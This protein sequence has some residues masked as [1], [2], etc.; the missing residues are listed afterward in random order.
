MPF[1]RRFTTGKRLSLAFGLMLLL[2]LAVSALGIRGSSLVFA[3]LKTIYEDRTIPLKQI[4]DIDS[5][6]LRNRILVTEM[7]RDPAQLPTLDA[8][9]Q[10]NIT[11]ITALWKDYMATYLT[12]EEKQL[13]T[14]FAEVRGHYVRQGLLAARDAVKAGDSA[15]AQSI[16][17][18]R[19]VTLGAQAKVAIDALLALQVRVGAESFRTAEATA[20]SVR[21]WSLA[22]AL[23]AVLIALGAGVFT[24]RSITAPMQEAVHFAEAVAQGDL[25]NRDA[26]PGRDEAARLIAALGAMAGSLR[27]IV[28]R[29]RHSSESIA[30]G[31]SEI[32]SGSL[33]LSQRTEEQ[34]ANLQQT[35][36]S[37]EQLSSTVQNNAS[38]AGQADALATRAA[39]AA[40]QGGGVVQQ[41][42]RTMQDISTSS[43][44]IAD[45][46]GVIDSIAFQT[47][48]LALNAAVEAARAGE[49]GKGFAVV[50]SEVR[51]LAQRSAQAARE[52]KALIGRSV[53]QVQSGSGL[54]DNAGAA[55]QG[56]VDQVRQVSVLIGEIASASHEQSRGIQQ[57]GDAVTQLDQV[58]QQNAALVEESSAAADSLQQQAKELAELVRVFRLA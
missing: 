9:L 35:A 27:D 30:T 46:I 25:R 33:D 55:M 6:M 42:V 26:T 3:D 22:A 39:A 23:A 52:I 40:S 10:A 21:G 7:M 14:T 57:I 50:A 2:I 36:A 47:N 11:T 48:I 13:A 1:L 24:T 12:D 4:G 15:K 8:Q 34:A 51:A 43:G 58:T 37:M 18:D 31:S 32:A 28:S 49:Q 41:V 16:Y 29:V 54:A 56:I 53:A 38:T 20:A 19:I 45:I 5:L 44:Q 17:G